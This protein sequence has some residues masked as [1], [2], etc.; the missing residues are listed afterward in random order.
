MPGVPVT[1]GDYRVL[2]TFCTRA[3]GAAGTRHFPASCC[4]LGGLAVNNSGAVRC[5]NAELCLAVI[6]RST[7]DEAIQLFL[8][9]PGLLRRSAPR[10]DGDGT[11]RA[12]NRRRPA[13]CAIAHWDRTIQYSEAPVME[14]RGRGVLDTPPARGMT[15]L[16]VR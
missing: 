3:A 10:N 15:V 14:A 13:L 12:L 5:E 2:T 8:A 4:F 16:V 6:A 7:C 11:P 1:C 9:V